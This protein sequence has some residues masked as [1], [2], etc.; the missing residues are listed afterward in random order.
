MK[1]ILFASVL[2][3][4]FQSFSQLGKVQIHAD[5]RVDGMIRKM[6]TAVPP[7]LT[8]QIVGYRVQLIFESDKKSIDA[9]RN[10]FV[11]MFPKVDTYITFESPYY[12]LKVGDFRTV[13][14]A[15]KVKAEIAETFPTAFVIKEFIN[16]PRID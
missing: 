3:L 14:E 5:P 13:A 16:L 10:R 7:N 8:P 15:E 4:G 12:I 6:G 9:S 2:F 1:I 11:S